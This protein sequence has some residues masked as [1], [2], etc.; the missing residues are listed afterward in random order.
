LPTSP[1]IEETVDDVTV[2]P[3]PH[4][5]KHRLGQGNEAEEIGLDHGAYFLILAFLHG[6]QIA[7]A[8]VVHQHVDAPEGAFRRRHGA[9][10][11]L[12]IGDV[13]R[14]RDGDRGVVGDEIAEPR[15]IERGSDDPMAAAQRENPTILRL[16]PGAGVV[17]Y[18]NIV[19]DLIKSTT[20]PRSS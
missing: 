13:E 8:G 4:A 17:A 18:P 1:P 10:R 14:E 5:G 20:T 15:D 6:R 3:R 11:L 12:A 7:V 9:G 19:G 2:S 16:K